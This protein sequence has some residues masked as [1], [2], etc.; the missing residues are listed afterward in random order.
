[1]ADIP[2]QK[3][4]SEV[5]LSVQESKLK[6]QIKQLEARQAMLKALEEIRDASKTVN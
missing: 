4:V 1:V 3:Y 2:T 6:Q 5:C